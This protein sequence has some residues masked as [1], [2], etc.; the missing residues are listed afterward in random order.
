VPVERR[1]AVRFRLSAPVIFRWSDQSGA[2]RE[3]AGR[4]RDISV[5]GAYVFSKILPPVKAKLSLDIELP[6]FEESAPERLHLKGEGGVARVENTGA[7]SGFAI[8]GPFTLHEV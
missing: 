5:V 8:R 3:E 4:L 2:R 1:E 6:P 7:E